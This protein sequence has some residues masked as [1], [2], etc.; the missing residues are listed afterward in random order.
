VRFARTF[1]CAIT[2]AIG[3]IFISPPAWSSCWCVLMTYFNGRSV[4]ALTCARMSA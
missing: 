1:L 3:S 2:S 4:I